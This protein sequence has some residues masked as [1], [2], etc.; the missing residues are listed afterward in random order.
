MGFGY[1]SKI[2]PWRVLLKKLLVS[3]PLVARGLAKKCSFWLS[4]LKYLSLPNSAWVAVN[5]WECFDCFDAWTSP[6]HKFSIAFKIV[7][8]WAGKMAQWACLLSL[9]SIWLQKPCAKRSDKH[10]HCVV[11]VLMHLAINTSI[12]NCQSSRPSFYSVETEIIAILVYFYRWLGTETWWWACTQALLKRV[13]FTSDQVLTQHTLLPAVTHPILIKNSHKDYSH[14]TSE[15]TVK[16]Q[17]PF[18]WEEWVD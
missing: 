6:L 17:S 8:F 5:K 11:Y 7:L 16:I 3:N 13:I 9:S 12:F 4:I 18:K 15:T 14:E 1:Q 10:V 2:P